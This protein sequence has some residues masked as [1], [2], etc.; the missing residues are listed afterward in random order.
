MVH[1]FFRCSI[2]LMLA[3]RLVPAQSINP[4]DLALGRVLVASR[5]LD[6]PGFAESVVVIVQY[7]QTGTI[8]LAINRK[9]DIPISRALSELGKAARDQSDPVYVGGPVET[10]GVRGL[11]RA[12]AAPLPVKPVVG[13]VVM[14]SERKALVREL[15]A[16][17]SPAVFRIYLGYCGWGKGQLEK[18]IRA[19]AWHI[20]SAAE[21][22]SNQGIF[23]SNPD[24]LWSRL[25][26]K[27]EL[28]LALKRELQRQLQLPGILRA[29]DR[30]EVGS[31]RRAIRKIE[32]G[33]VE[34]IER[35]HPEL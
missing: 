31:E 7:D 32:I 19:G 15:G 8:G 4:K 26:V 1:L 11:L 12:R 9:T 24:T 30:T 22:G 18:E 16:K 33:V 25:I 2:A 13:D 6:D 27:T 23:D 5:D 20:F 35:F 10:E 14:I 28:E 29:P 3:A 21:L 34:E 17:H